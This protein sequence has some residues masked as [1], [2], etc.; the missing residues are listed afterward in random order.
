MASL[1]HRLL[2]GLSAFDRAN[3]QE[4]AEVPNESAMTIRSAFRAPDFREDG[5]LAGEPVVGFIE[6]WWDN[7]TGNLARVAAKPTP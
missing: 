7:F 1:Q 5:L 2:P 4:L 6:E 3:A